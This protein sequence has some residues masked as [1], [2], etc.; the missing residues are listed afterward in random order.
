MV[1]LLRCYQKEGSEALELSGD[2]TTM[3]RTSA[4][5]EALISRA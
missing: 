4:G 1:E 5:S 3:H 2:T